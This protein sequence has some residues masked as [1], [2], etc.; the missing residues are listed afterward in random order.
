MRLAELSYKSRPLTV[1]HKTELTKLEIFSK[2]KDTKV[3]GIAFLKIVLEW[4]D[5]YI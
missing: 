4:S 2:A 5:I 1:L 3:G